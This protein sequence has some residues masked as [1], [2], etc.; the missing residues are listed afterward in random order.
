VAQCA[1]IVAALLV[2][3]APAAQRLT[4][5]FWCSIG[6]PVALTLTEAWLAFV[7]AY[8]TN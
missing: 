3:P 2:G 1:K 5:R 7:L 4:T 6:L 8:V